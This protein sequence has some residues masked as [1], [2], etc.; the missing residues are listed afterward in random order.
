V[1]ASRALA[2]L[3]CLRALTH[4]GSGFLAYV[5]ER[6]SLLNPFFRHGGSRQYSH[7]ILC[8][9]PFP[10][11]GQRICT[12]GPF[13]PCQMVVRCFKYDA[14]HY[15]PFGPIHLAGGVFTGELRF[16]ARTLFDAGVAG[17]TNE[18]TISLVDRWQ[19][20]RKVF[21]WCPVRPVTMTDTRQPSSTLFTSRL[22]KKVSHCFKG[23]APLWFHRRWPI[24]SAVHKVPFS[25][26][27]LWERSDR[28]FLLKRAKYNIEVR[29]G[30]PSG[31]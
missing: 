4:F 25:V 10:R 22:G 9:V 8:Y 7:C 19:H 20:S 30:V 18:E 12:S 17:L 28:I 11:C 23:V 15:F 21:F 5:T 24:Q 16:A 13:V 14:L 2:L 27:Q 31:E 3:A 6:S 26:L 1:S 29:D